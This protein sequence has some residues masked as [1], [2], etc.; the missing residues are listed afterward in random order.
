MKLA[1]LGTGEFGV[2]AIRALLAAGHEVV[3]VVSQPDRPAGRGRQTQPTPVH[4]ACDQ[5]GVPHAQADDINQP[6][7]SDLLRCAE[8]GVVAAF[9]QKI[10]PALLAAPPHGMLNIHASLLPRYRGAAPYQWAILNG[11]ATT[12]VTIFRLNDR[13]DA[14]A[15]YGQIETPIGDAET[16]DELHDRLAVLGAD[17]IVRV[18]A[19]I[20]AGRA[21]PREQDP[22]LATRA[23][24]LRKA[25]GYVDWDQPAAACVRRIHGL[26]S[27]PAASMS[28]ISRGGRS[29]RIQLAR[30][31]VADTT[32]APSDAHPPGTFLA[33]R[34]VQA[35]RG[36]VELLEVKPAGGTLM[37]FEAF[38][39]GRRVGGGDRL[40]RLLA[41]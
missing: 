15:I 28:F 7:F 38:A 31:R 10:G 6:Q 37:P 22:R 24:K 40:A 30:A 36:R 35:G 39:N 25:D 4:A 21:T 1:F 16:A 17:L 27:W 32:A 18:V 19:E 26:W 20:A 9:G 34:T 12:G 41:E 23:P 29:E 2:P 8:L 14:G 33:D 3:A 5:L 11:D 13:W